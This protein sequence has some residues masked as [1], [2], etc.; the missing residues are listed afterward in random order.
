MKLLGWLIIEIWCLS[1]TTVVFLGYG[2]E[3]GSC[4]SIY[5][6][7]FYYLCQKYSMMPKQ[8]LD[9]KSA[10]TDPFVYISC[11]KN[12]KN[13]FHDKHAWCVTNI[14]EP[15][16]VSHALVLLVLSK[17]SL[18]HRSASNNIPC[19]KDW[20]WLHFRKVSIIFFTFYKQTHLLYAIQQK[21]YYHLYRSHW[22]RHHI[23]TLPYL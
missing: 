16:C 10:Y 15:Y 20:S 6:L 2:I 17:R 3:P 12:I 4:I 23:C 1:C 19:D 21:G 11:W 7:V 13:V 8:D 5:S 18:F 22:C 14:K 9:S